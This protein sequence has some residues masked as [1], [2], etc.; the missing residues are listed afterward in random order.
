MHGSLAEEVG[1]AAKEL[2]LAR[3]I[4]ADIIAQEEPRLCGA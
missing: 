1:L 3:T 2:A 4:L